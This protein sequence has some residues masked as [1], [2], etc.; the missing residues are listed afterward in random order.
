MCII[1]S[2][3]YYVKILLI[4][5]T[6]KKIF[7]LNVVSDFKTSRRKDQFVFCSKEYDNSNYYVIVYIKVL[8][9]LCIF[10]GMSTEMTRRGLVGLG[11]FC[12]K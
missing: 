3:C 11:D 2:C 12:F 7:L 10:T 9:H 1:F 8:N 5:C 4:L 6:C